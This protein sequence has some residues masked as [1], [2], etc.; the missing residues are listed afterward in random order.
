MV[1]YL[2]DT[3]TASYIIRGNRPEI[4]RR[5]ASVP[6]TDVCIS[7]ITRAEL[8]YGVRRKPGAEHL[9]RVVARFLATVKSLP[10]DDDAADHFAIIAAELDAGGRR[11]GTFDTMIAAHALATAA[12]VVTNNVEHFSRVPGLAVENWVDS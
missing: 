1:R 12:V 10:W 2:L 4:D 9:A 5:L 7:S 8:L 6:T 3:D 11:I